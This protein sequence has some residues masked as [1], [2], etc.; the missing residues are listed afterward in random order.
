MAFVRSYRWRYGRVG[1]TCLTRRVMI[2]APK[3]TPSH[4]QVTA[5]RPTGWNQW[6]WCHLCHG[7]PLRGLVRQHFSGPPPSLDTAENGKKVRSHVYST[8]IFLWGFLW[9]SFRAVFTRFV[10]KKNSSGS[11]GKV[12]FTDWN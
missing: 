1:G 10:E 7:L 2:L 12:Y 11:L 8:P 3:R 4:P 5:S 9:S 6:K